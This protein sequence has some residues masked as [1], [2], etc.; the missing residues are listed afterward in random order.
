MTSASHMTRQNNDIITNMYPV[1]VVIMSLIIPAV[2][3][4]V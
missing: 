2:I 3:K 4:D 1:D